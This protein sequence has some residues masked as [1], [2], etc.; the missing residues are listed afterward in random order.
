MAGV[1]NHLR[2]K[3]PVDPEL[4][5]SAATELTAQMRAIEGFQGFH[6]IQTSETEVILVIFGDDVDVLNRIATEV[7]SPWMTAKVVPLLAGPPDRQIGPTIAS[8]QPR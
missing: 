1:V 5:A 4:F 3:E 2:F 7:G 8:S 6:V